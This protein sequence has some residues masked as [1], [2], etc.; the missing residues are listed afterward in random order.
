ML[1]RQSPFVPGLFPICLFLSIVLLSVARPT[2]KKLTGD[3]LPGGMIIRLGYKN[4]WDEQYGTTFRLYNRFDRSTNFT[5]FFGTIVGLTTSVLDNQLV[6]QTREIPRAEVR[7]ARGNFGV[8]KYQLIKLGQDSDSQ[9]VTNL[10]VHQATQDFLVQELSDPKKLLKQTKDLFYKKYDIPAVDFW[11]DVADNGEYISLVLIYLTLLEGR[12]HEP[13]L[14]K[15]TL[16]EWIKI[17]RAVKTL[18]LGDDYVTKDP[19]FLAIFYL[20]NGK[21]EA[22][23]TPFNWAAM[24]E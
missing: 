18:G 12:D 17:Y 16:G 23:E 19:H 21:Y 3:R 9:L 1:L 24:L 4:I 10:D 15:G 7:N 14:A 13:A 20:L 22:P 2:T 6:V 11:P 5:I 8:R